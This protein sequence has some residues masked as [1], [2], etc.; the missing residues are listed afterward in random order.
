MIEAR[1]DELIRQHTC[2]RIYVLIVDNKLL[3]DASKGKL[4]KNDIRGKEKVRCS[5]E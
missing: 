4:E 5:R 1:L 3:L 2:K